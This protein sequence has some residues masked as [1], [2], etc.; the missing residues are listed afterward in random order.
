MVAEYRKKITE[1]LAAISE[2]ARQDTELLL[3]FALSRTREQLIMDSVYVPTEAEQERIDA[4]VDRRKK[5]EPIAY[6]LGHQ[7]FWTL[8]LMVS[9][10]TLVPRPETECLVDWVLTAFQKQTVLT[11]ADLGTGTGAIALAI[12]SEKAT[13]QIDA[14]DESYEALAIARKNAKKYALKNVS[15]YPGDWCDALPDKKYDVIVSNPPYI[16]AGDPHLAR[17][18]YEPQRALVSGVEGLDAIQTIALQAKD[19]LNPGGILVIEHGYD[20]SQMAWE[21]FSKAGYHDIHNHRDLSDT[22]RFITGIYA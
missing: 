21:I 14:V 8:D 7:P 1:T 19:K 13:W 9:E 16:A 18:S 11:L 12:A 6:I 5:G 2:S 4:V 17:L 22:P 20:Q 15:F 10:D 3:M